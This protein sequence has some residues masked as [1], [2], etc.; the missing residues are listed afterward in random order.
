M[1]P[2]T[3]LMNV[4]T[5]IAP[6]ITLVLALML[7]TMLAPVLISM[8]APVLTAL[9]IP[10]TWRWRVYMP[11]NNYRWAGIVVVIMPC[12]W[13]VIVAMSVIAVDTVAVVVIVAVVA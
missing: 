4:F 13:C 1:M 8:L 12:A 10:V 2:T 7:P 6:V 5:A 3:L 9:V 11:V